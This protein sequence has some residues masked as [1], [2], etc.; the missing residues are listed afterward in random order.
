MPA[1]AGGHALAGAVRIHA[2]SRKAIEKGREMTMDSNAKLYQDLTK[3]LVTREEISA[4]VKKLG[5]QITKDY[6]GRELMVVGILKGA[7]VFYSDLI[8]EIDLPLRTDF[9]AVSSYGSATKS[10]GVVQLRKDLDRPIEGMDVLIVED[11]VDSGMTLSYLKRVF[12]D[13]GA[14]SVRIATLLDKPARRRV[15]LKADYF[16]FEIPDEFV[17][18]YGLDFDEKYRNLPDIGVLHPRIYGEG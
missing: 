7:I 11:I 17:V 8:R 15:D 3:I 16:C 13:R 14:A 1:L 4:A 10:S 9:M 12:A 18:G 2:K 5:Q 6:E